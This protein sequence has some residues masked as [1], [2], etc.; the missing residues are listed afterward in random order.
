VKKNEY[1]EIF[2]LLV[3]SLGEVERIRANHSFSRRKPKGS[4]KNNIFLHN[5]KNNKGLNFF[6]KK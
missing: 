4:G 6:Y 1:G 2:P 3:V 5:W